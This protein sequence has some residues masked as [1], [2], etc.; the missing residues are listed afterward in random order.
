MLLRAY[1]LAAGQQGQTC[2]SAHLRVS[3]GAHTGAPL[4]MNLRID[5]KPTVSDA[6]PLSTAWFYPTGCTLR[7]QAIGRSSVFPTRPLPFLE[8][9]PRPRPRYHKRARVYRSVRCL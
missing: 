8:N 4:H 6:N 5:S 9:N 2:V 1:A 7:Q 3:L